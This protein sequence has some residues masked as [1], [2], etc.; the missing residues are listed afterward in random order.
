[1]QINRS[2]MLPQVALDEMTDFVNE[3]VRRLQDMVRDLKQPEAEK[4]L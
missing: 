3:M 1:M 4:S 2:G